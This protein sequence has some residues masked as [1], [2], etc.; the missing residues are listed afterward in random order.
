MCTLICKWRHCT[1]LERCLYSCPFGPLLSSAEEHNTN[2]KEEFLEFHG[3]TFTVFCTFTFKNL[4]I[5]DV[6]PKP[7]LKQQLDQLKKKMLSVV[8]HFETQWKDMNQS[9]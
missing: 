9:T 1:H 4:N 2:L 5:S 6:T 8:V 3:E 7:F